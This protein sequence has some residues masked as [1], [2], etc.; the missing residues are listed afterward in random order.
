MVVA[1]IYWDRQSEL[2][3]DAIEVAASSIYGVQPAANRLAL[4]PNAPTLT[5]AMAE[6]EFRAQ[7]TTRIHVDAKLAFA[8]ARDDQVAVSPFD[9][10]WTG[11]TIIACLD[12]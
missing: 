6:C 12:D 8:V 9:W 4:D 7:A 5:Y 1:G 3:L 11:S 10:V 2:I